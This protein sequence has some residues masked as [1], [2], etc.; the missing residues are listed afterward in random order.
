MAKF[1]GITPLILGVSIFGLLL[2]FYSWFFTSLPKVE[3]TIKLE[4]IEKEK[5]PA[6]VTPTE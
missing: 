3:Q 4:K 5:L 6:G 1:I 2:L